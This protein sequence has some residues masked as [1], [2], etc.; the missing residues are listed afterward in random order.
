MLCAAS[1]IFPHVLFS[2]VGTEKNPLYPKR[3]EGKKRILLDPDSR[4]ITKIVQLRE[5]LVEELNRRILVGYLVEVIGL[6]VE[7]APDPLVIFRVI[8]A[9]RRLP[10]GEFPKLSCEYVRDSRNRL[11]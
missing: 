6:F 1:M 11:R 10:V 5:H 9:N 2:G 8:T 4:T 7:C 3:T